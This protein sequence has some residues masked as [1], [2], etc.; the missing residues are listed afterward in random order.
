MISKFYVCINH[1]FY[2]FV[3]CV[4]KTGLKFKNCPCFQGR[5]QGSVPL[6]DSFNFLKTELTLVQKFFFPY[7]QVNIDLHVYKNVGKVLRGVC[8]CIHVLFLLGG[9]GH[10]LSLI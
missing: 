4:I 6:D 8:T 7:Q 2:R 1:C 5:N 3:K 10:S 9:L